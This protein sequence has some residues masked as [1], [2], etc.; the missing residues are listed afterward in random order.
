M[1]AIRSYYGEQVAFEKSGYLPSVGVSGAYQIDGQDGPLTYVTSAARGPV[2]GFVK[3]LLRTY[4][5]PSAAVLLPVITSYSIHYTKLYDVKR[6]IRL[7]AESSLAVFKHHLFETMLDGFN[8]H[9][10]SSFSCKSSGI[11]FK[12]QPYFK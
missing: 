1:Y 4:L 2:V 8:I 10:I 3:R 5:D 9:L 12:G 11:T 7:A 6:R